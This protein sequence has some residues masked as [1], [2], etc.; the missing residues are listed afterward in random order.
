METDELIWA[1]IEHNSCTLDDDNG[2]EVLRC[3]HYVG[4][5]GDRTCSARRGGAGM[6]PREFPCENRPRILVS[7]QEYAIWKLTK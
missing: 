5:C 6:D 4:M 3:N 2:K 7:K 1:D